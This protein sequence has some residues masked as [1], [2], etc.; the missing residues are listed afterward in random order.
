MPSVTVLS[1]PNALFSN[2]SFV[3]NHLNTSTWVDY[4]EMSVDFLCELGSDLLLVP[5]C[6]VVDE[7]VGPDAV[8]YSGLVVELVLVHCSYL[9]F[10]YPE[11]VVELV[12]SRDLQAYYF[13]PA[14]DSVV[15]Y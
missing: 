8:A 14:Y 6:A 10:G 9:E 11:F 5:Y 13:V 12:R 7:S 15:A 3:G 4:Q 2:V 1:C